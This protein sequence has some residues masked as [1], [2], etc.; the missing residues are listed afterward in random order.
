MANP[1]LIEKRKALEVI[2]IKKRQVWERMERNKLLQRQFRDICDVS[3]LEHML[4]CHIFAY[5]LFRE[6]ETDI[7][8][9]DK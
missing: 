6:I 5:R 8:G 3:I 2:R 4:E 1:V 7:R 9:L